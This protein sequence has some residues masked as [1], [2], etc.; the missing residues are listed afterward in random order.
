MTSASC[1]TC[2]GLGIDPFLD[3]M[4]VD[5]NGT[6]REPYFE[7]PVDHIP[8]H[9]VLNERCRCDHCQPF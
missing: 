9:L 7:F 8:S 5:C 1:P 3:D 2:S 6:G 4:C